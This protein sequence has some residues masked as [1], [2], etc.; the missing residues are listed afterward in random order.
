MFGQAVTK[1]NGVVYDAETKQTI[2]FAD[3]YLLGRGTNVGVSTD[4]DGYYTIETRFASDTV[5]ARYLG[6]KDA[7][8]RI[9][10]GQKQTINFTLQSESVRMET[11]E[12]KFKKEKYSKKNNPA[13]EL[14]M[15]VT[16]NKK[17]IS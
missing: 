15:K 4:A 6:Y 9:K 1:V 7:M 8:F 11:V 10:K 13:L 14:L 5:V 17:E 12:V 3:V 2:P 16:S